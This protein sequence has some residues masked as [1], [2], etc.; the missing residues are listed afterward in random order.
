MSDDFSSGIDQWDLRRVDPGKDGHTVRVNDQ[1]QLVIDSGP[2]RGNGRGFLLTK[3]S[4]PASAELCAPADPGQV[5]FR[6]EYEIVSSNDP[7]SGGLLVGTTFKGEDAGATRILD[8]LAT[9]DPAGRVIPWAVFPGGR[10]FCASESPA[11]AGLGYPTR[12]PHQPGKRIRVD[13]IAGL[14]GT[15]ERIEVFVDGELDGTL[16]DTTGRDALGFEAGRLGFWLLLDRDVTINDFAVRQLAIED[17]DDQ[18]PSIA[19]NESA[20]EGY[21]AASELIFTTTVYGDEVGYRGQNLHQ[22]VTTALA[23]A[24]AE[25]GETRPLYKLQGYCREPVLSRD[26]R[27]AAAS[28][29][30]NGRG[31]VYLFNTRTG[32]GWNISSNEFRDR[33]PSFSPD[34]RALTFLSD[35]DGSWQVYVMNADGGEVRCL[36]NSASRHRSPSFSPDGTRIAFLSD[37]EGDFDVYTVKPD[38]SDLRLLVPQRGANAYDPVWSPDSQ[39]LCWS[40]QSRQL[41]RLVLARA[42]GSEHRE[43]ATGAQDGPLRFEHGAPTSITSLR[44]SPDGS[45]V[46][47]AFTDYR[48]SG[49]FVLDVASGRIRKLLDAKPLMPYPFDWYCTAAANPRWC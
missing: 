47:G 15:C 9:S 48:T 42:D 25:S 22:Q 34:R 10:P 30:V 29:W 26:R 8:S 45:R 38:G 18:A 39:W 31:Q 33:S 4:F 24:D 49:I 43:L 2:E 44:F 17:D 35:R 46:A 19:N 5:F 21:A 32:R 27:L 7:N 6:V 20:M 37:R 16:V 41:R 28:V 13:W 3:R 1:G 40:I 11:A 36:S 23:I 12:L 14:H